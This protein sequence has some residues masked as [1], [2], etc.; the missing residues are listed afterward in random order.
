MKVIK[1]FILTAE[2]GH[3]LT[4]GETYGTTVILPSAEDVPNWHEITK[5]A[6]DAI[7]KEVVQ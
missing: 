6:Y 5:E 1:Q 7:E 4:N 2:E 3:Y